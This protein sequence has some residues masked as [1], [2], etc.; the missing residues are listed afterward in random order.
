MDPWR[1][2]GSNAEAFGVIY[3]KACAK[4]TR[5]QL[6]CQADSGSCFVTMWHYPILNQ[7]GNGY[8]LTDTVISAN[9]IKII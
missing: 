3:N 5:C 4:A 1:K 7:M 8:C 6:T 9:I 2:T